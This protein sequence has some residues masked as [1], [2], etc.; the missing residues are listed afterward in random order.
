[1]FSTLMFAKTGIFYLLTNGNFSN[2]DLDEKNRCRSNVRSTMQCVFYQREYVLQKWY[3]FQSAFYR[4]VC[5][6]ALPKRHHEEVSLQ[7]SQNSSI[8]RCRCNYLVIKSSQMSSWFT[9]RWYG[10]LRAMLWRGHQHLVSTFY[11]K[12][13][14]KIQCA[15]PSICSGTR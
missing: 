14:G 9:Y 11:S 7:V 6:L 10:C 15:F 13:L 2:Q 1:M 8:R 12:K 3:Q 5:L 4:V